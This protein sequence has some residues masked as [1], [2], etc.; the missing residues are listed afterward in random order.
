M[1]PQQHIQ[2][3]TPKKD[4]QRNTLSQLLSNQKQNDNNQKIEKIPLQEIN[5]PKSIRKSQQNIVVIADFT[6]RKRLRAIEVVA[7]GSFF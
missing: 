2:I 7:A 3:Y 5:I 4:H 6:C 1:V